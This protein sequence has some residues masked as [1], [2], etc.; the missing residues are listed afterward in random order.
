MTEKRK[1]INIVQASERVRVNRTTMHR[2]I[3]E[4]KV[5]IIRTSG[6]RTLIYEDSLFEPSR[7]SSNGQEKIS[8]PRLLKP[9]S[10][11]R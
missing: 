9:Q 1:L 7:S 10:K 2:W 4:K 6:N 8:N 11:S 3:R 5:E